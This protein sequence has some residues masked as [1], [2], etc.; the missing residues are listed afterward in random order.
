MR[1]QRT[2]SA[3]AA[4][5]QRR[6]DEDPN[7]SDYLHNENPSL[8]ALGN[9]NARTRERPKT[10]K[11]KNVQNCLRTASQSSNSGNTDPKGGNRPLSISWHVSPEIKKRKKMIFPTKIGFLCR[12][13]GIF[14]PKS[15]FLKP[16]NGFFCPKLEFFCQKLDFSVKNWISVKSWIFQ[17]KTGFFLSES[18]RAQRTGGAT[19]A[20]G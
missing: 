1:V 11:S 18:M 15:G 16:K 4:R 7:P 17:S 2:S 19:A 14:L 9:L 13:T 12:K 8:V 20:T 10:P 6:Q 3:P 5:R